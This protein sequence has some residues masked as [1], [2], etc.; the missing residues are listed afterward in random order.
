MKVIAQHAASMTVDPTRQAVMPA[1]WYSAPD[2]RMP[3]R[4]PVALAA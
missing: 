3:S 4:R 2:S 1:T